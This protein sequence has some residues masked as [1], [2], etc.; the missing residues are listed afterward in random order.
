MPKNIPEKPLERSI[1]RFALKSTSYI[2]SPASLVAHT[3]FFIG[4]FSLSFFGVAFEQILL[5]LTTLVSLEAIY[6]AIFIQISVNQQAV[7]L[8]AVSADVEE[9]GS[10]VDEISRDIDEI[11]EEVE[12]LAEEVEEIGEDI[13][14]DDRE[15]DMLHQANVERIE[16]IEELLSELVKEMR[17]KKV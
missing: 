16:K 11:Q 10:D 13:E 15:D 1:D 12:D 5:L 4:I 9:I 8:Q 2:G 7:Q 6:L 14:E 17:K 3:L